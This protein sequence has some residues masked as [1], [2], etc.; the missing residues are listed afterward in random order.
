[1]NTVNFGAANEIAV[2]KRRKGRARRLHQARVIGAGDVERHD[3]L[4]A[5]VLGGRDGGVD[6]RFFARDDDLAGRVEIRGLD[7]ELAAQLGDLRALLADDRRH[8]AHRLL[9]RQL[10]KPAALGDDPEAGGEIKDPGRA[11]GGDF[12]EA[13]AQG[14]LR[15]TGRQFRLARATP[16]ARP[17]RGRR[18]P[19]GRP[20]SASARFPGPSKQT[21]ARSQ[22]ST[23]LAS[24]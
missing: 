13:Q 2:Q 22:P 10:H 11:I 5:A 1:M 9:T 14:E 6:L 21:L 19:A 15:F 3:F 17:G 24:S 7:V 4:H 12:P 20:W 18:A 8:A 23:R 16:P